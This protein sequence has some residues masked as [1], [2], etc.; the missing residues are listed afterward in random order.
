[1][2][3][4]LQRRLDETEAFEG[5]P[6]PE[7]R[8]V[9]EM[10]SSAGPWQPGALRADYH[11]RREELRLRFPDQWVLY[12]LSFDYESA[13]STLQ[14]GGAYRTLHEAVQAENALPPD[15]R[16]YTVEYFEANDLSVVHISTPFVADIEVEPAHPQPVEG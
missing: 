8:R 3:P 4:D 5:K 11:R 12:R 13:R 1:M 6:N 10:L 15:Q 2:W 7:L 16:R 14:L 9:F